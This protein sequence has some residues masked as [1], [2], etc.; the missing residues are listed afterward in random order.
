MQL[1]DLAGRYTPAAFRASMKQLKITSRAEPSND[2]TKGNLGYWLGRA[3]IHS[4][5]R[6]IGQ[7][8]FVQNVSAVSRVVK[9]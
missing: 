2:E 9:E 4:Y 3:K 5:D 6:E 8:I 7:S 1:P